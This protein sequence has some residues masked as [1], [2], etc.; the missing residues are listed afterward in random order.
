[1]ADVRTTARLLRE[2]WTFRQVEPTAIPNSDLESWMPAEVPG[3][4][5]LDLLR[6]GVIPDPFEGMYERTVQWVDDADWAYRCD[7]DVTAEELSGA[8]HLLRFE[9]LD[10]IA[11]VVLND[12]V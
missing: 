12:Q 10:T 8:R 7:V 2:G 3:H 6:L 5:H 9:G 11:T 4:V 1:M